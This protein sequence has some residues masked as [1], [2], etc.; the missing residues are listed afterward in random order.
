[1]I[2]WMASHVGLA[3]PHR[4]ERTIAVLVALVRWAAFGTLRRFGLALV[5]VLLGVVVLL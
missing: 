4:F 1:M 2:R 3:R 5:V